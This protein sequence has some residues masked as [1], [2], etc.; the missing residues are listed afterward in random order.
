[1]T[2]AIGGGQL[3]VGDFTTSGREHGKEQVCAIFVDNSLG[4]YAISDDGTNKSVTVSPTNSARFF[5]L[6]RP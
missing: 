4:C 5:R 3:I 1:M 2:T 6:R